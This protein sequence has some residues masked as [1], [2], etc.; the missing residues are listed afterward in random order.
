MFGALLTKVGLDALKQ[1]LADAKAKVQSAPTAQALILV[2]TPFE[3]L[4]CKVF[5]S[6]FST[7]TMAN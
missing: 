3:L 1:R 5:S 4:F 6:H 7:P 2:V